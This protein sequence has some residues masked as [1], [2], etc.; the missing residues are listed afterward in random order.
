MYEDLPFTRT[1]VLCRYPNGFAG[2]ME[3]ARAFKVLL[4]VELQRP[5]PARIFLLGLNE[6][7]EEFMSKGR[8]DWAVLRGSGLLARV[9]ELAVM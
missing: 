6:Q 9:V 3:P 2:E 5:L 1:L 4:Q 7:V 8:Q